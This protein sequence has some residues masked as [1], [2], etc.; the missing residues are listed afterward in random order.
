MSSPE[1]KLLDEIREMYKDTYANCIF[2][3]TNRL[4]EYK[5]LGSPAEIRAVLEAVEGS[6]PWRH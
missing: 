1:K 2:T 5:Q 6:A 3:L 4:E